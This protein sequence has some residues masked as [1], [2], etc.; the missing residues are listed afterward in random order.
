MTSYEELYFGDDLGIEVV[1]NFRLSLAYDRLYFFKHNLGQDLTGEDYSTS[2]SM[3]Y[4]WGDDVFNI[5]VPI[6]EG[7]N[8]QLSIPRCPSSEGKNIVM[9]K[10]LNH[11]IMIKII[12]LF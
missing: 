12:E 1:L 5:D 2:M 6:L 11:N 9:M 7:E 4:C 8:E 10:S 3:A